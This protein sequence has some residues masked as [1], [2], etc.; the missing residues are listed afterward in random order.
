MTSLITEYERL[1]AGTHHKDRVEN[2]HFYVFSAAL[3]DGRGDLYVA[4][5][6]ARALDRLNWG[7]SFSSIDKWAEGVPATTS[8]TIAMLQA[9]APE[10]ASADV[11]RIAWARNAI[12]EWTEVPYLHEFD[13]VLASSSLALKALSQVYSGPQG[14]MP[15]AVDPELFQ[16]GKRARDIPVL[17]TANH[18]GDERGLVQT[19]RDLAPKQE[20]HWYGKGL[21]KIADLPESILLH[22]AVA[23]TD[24]AQLYARSQIVLDD[25]T[26]STRAY[27]CQNSRLFEALAAGAL[28]VTNLATGLDELGLSDVPVVSPGEALGP[29]LADMLSD[30]VAREAIVSRLRQ[31]VLSRH[32]FAHRAAVLE[33]FLPGARSVQQLRGNVRQLKGFS[34]DLQEW[35][36]HLTNEV[37]ELTGSIEASTEQRLRRVLSRL[38]RRN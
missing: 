10:Y 16:S 29:V 14:L 12:A 9:A 33:Q 11:V 23:Y 1:L 28:V 22:E 7:V 5:G 19:L 34:A 3:E 25:L 21:E 38:F 27:G 31:Q 4:L 13:G 30:N 35:N 32:T 26:E 24:I 8:V 15:I 2:V 37:G 36:A 18:W 20:V 6:L 17:T